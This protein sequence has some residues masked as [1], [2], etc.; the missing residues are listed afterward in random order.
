[1]R[2]AASKTRLKTPSKENRR[3]EW[4]AFLLL[5]NSLVRHETGTVIYPTGAVMVFETVEIS[6]AV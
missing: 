1:M 5:T 2:S 4:G 6:T 3:R